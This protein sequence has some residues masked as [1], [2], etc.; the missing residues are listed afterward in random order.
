MTTTVNI[1]FK[2]V[3]GRLEVSPPQMV[4]T[5]EE[6]VRPI[7]EQ[8]LGIILPIVEGHPTLLVWQHIDGVEALS[9]SEHAPSE[10]EEL[11]SVDSLMLIHPFIQGTV[12][13]LDGLQP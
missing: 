11:G 7:A 1:S 12:L 9:D 8:T 13:L 6:E 3:V 10:V 4:G 5:T 2:E